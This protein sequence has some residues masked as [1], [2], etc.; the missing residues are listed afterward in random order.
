MRRISGKHQREARATTQTQ[1]EAR[2]HARTWT[3]AA[4][5]SVRPV[6]AAEEPKGLPSAAVSIPPAMLLPAAVEAAALVGEEGPPD[7][8][9]AMIPCKWRG[10][11]RGL[12]KKG[13]V[14]G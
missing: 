5:Y 14:V 1:R 9:P 2:A 13:A 8:C 7:L 10:R 3:D 12:R 4:L 6:A 11:G